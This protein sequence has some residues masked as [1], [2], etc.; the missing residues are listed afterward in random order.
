[1]PELV[2]GETDFVTCLEILATIAEYEIGYH[3]VVEKDGLKLD[4]SVTS[5]CRRHMITLHREF[6]QQTHYYRPRLNARIQYR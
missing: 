2:S 1:M 4:L 5:T 6:I 3:Y